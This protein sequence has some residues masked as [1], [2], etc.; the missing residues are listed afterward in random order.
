[1]FVRHTGG[2][3]ARPGQL[4]TV[5]I[6]SFNTRELLLRCLD[7]V[8]GAAEA[9][10]AEVWV[11]DNGSDDG[12]AQAAREHARWAKVV[13]PDRNLGFGP[14]VNLVAARTSSDW[15]L[16]ANADIALQPGALEAMLEEGAEPGVGCV[17]PR[18]V[19]PGGETQHSVHPFPTVPLSLLFN[20]GLHHLNRAIGDRLCLEGFWDPERPR[21]VPWAIGA[22]VLLRRAAFEEVG[23]FDEQ[24]W[25][26]AEDLDVGW[27][28]A[29]AGWITRYEPAARVLHESGAATSIAFGEEQ[30]SRFMAASYATLQRRRG[31]A[32]MWATAA[33]NIAGAGTRAAWT[34]PLAKIAPRWRSRSSEDR[35]WLRA[36][37][38]GLRLRS[39]LTKST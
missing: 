35:R 24:R 9:G 13:E 12:S 10:R 30:A 18:L 15:I 11:V 17:A 28:L 8:A 6:V 7:S 21:S 3:N 38:Q 26:Y 20:L 36:H 16:A 27:R 32:R 2:V 23:G 19:L 14:A 39:T 29:K 5:A 22:C 31:S 1:M 34:T 33:I 37:V 4:V 25:M